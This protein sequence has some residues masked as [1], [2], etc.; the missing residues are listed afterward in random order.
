MYSFKEKNKLYYDLQNADFAV[1]DLDLLCKVSPTDQIIERAKRNP[2]RN[3]K[4]V[5]YRLLDLQTA[6]EIRLNRRSHSTVNSGGPGA[7][8][9]ALVAAKK[10][11]R[12]A[13]MAAGRAAAKAKRDAEKAAA[14]GLKTES[15]EIDAKKAELEEKEL[16]LSEKESELE[17]KESELEDKET[18]LQKVEDSLN[19]EKKK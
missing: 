2:E 13:N 11:E 6:D 3:F 12:L 5:L 18:E 8:E 1:A 9:A 15:K 4:E 14:A 10:V 17:D 16:E 19:A 7:D